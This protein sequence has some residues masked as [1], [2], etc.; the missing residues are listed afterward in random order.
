ML[1]RLVSVIPQPEA[2]TL[3][4]RIDTP[5]WPLTRYSVCQNAIH[6]APNAGR[7]RISLSFFRV[8]RDGANPCCIAR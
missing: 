8:Y 1:R 6:P 2:K 4:G 5:Q 7:F 3:A